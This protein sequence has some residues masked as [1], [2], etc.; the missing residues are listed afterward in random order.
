MA[1]SARVLAVRDALGA[2]RAEQADRDASRARSLF[3]APEPA[4]SWEAPRSATPEWVEHTLGVIR[5]LAETRDT[6]SA[7]DVK[8]LVD[9]TYDLR[10][11]GAVLVSAARRGWIEK[12]PYIDGGRE[13][14]GRPIVEWRSRLRGVA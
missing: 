11:I 13:R 3:D 7:I 4:P 8:P 14:H 6:L 2:Y 10:A 5:N 9:E 1:D 12:G